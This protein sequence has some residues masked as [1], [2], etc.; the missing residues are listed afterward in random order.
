MGVNHLTSAFGG[1]TLTVDEMVRDPLYI[2]ERVLENLDGAFLEEALFRNG[3]TNDGVVA[4]RE[5]AAP[6]LNDN[7]EEVAEFAEIPV[8][9]LNR[10][11]LKSIIGVKTA[12]A[13][14]VSWEMQRFNKI[15]LL[16]LQTTALQNTMIENGVN[17]AL[18]AFDNANIPTLGVGINWEDNAAEPMRDIRQAKRLISLAK[19]DKPAD[20]PDAPERLMGYRPDIIVL[21][22]ATLDLALFHDNVQKFY[23]GNAAVE[24]PVY[25][26]IQPST[27]GGL[28]VVTSAF[29]PEG[30][31]Y[32]MQSGTAGFVS[33]AEP[34]TLT[35]LYSE[36][37]ENGFGGS[38]MSHRVDAFRH[39]VVAIDN[40]KAVV[41]LTGIEA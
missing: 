34:L 36:S 32:I 31:C 11:K 30:D 3:G 12:L 33:E 2:P 14:R 1:D 13:I 39:R 28:R 9:D 21:N 23:N 18:A 25:Q 29:I 22:E 8:S 41:K 35:P 37:G 27:L 20:E 16:T 6:Y 19:S 38:R 4:Y 17:S 10:G 15:D 7:S 40:P 5:A 24:N 26:G